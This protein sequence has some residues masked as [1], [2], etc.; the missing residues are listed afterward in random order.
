MAQLAVA[1]CQFSVGAHIAANA[2]Q[3]EQ[4]MARASE[5]GARVAHF[6][7]GALSGYAAAKGAIVPT[8][9]L[10]RLGWHNGAPSPAS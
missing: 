10:G 7:E 9:P 1:T 5:G 3:I 8:T 6:P 4:L 2:G